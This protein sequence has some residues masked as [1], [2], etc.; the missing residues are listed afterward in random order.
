MASDI[1]LG[2]QNTMTKRWSKEKKQIHMEIDVILSVLQEG[3][4]GSGGYLVTPVG[5]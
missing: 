4:R 2:A 5:H 3:N 1:K